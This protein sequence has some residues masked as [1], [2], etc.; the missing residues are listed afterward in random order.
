VG[1][2]FYSPTSQNGW[3]YGGSK[4]FSQVSFTILQGLITNNP[5][6]LIRLNVSG[7]D[8]AGKSAL[9]RY[10]KNRVFKKRPIM[11]LKMMELRIK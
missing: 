9:R 6:V 8:I 10:Y 2:V 1:V 3:H 4:M 11:W 5:A 7:D